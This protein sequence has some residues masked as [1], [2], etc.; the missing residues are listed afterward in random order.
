MTDR[1][2]C[3]RF[4]E[5]MKRAAVIIATLIACINGYAQHKCSIGLDLGNTLTHKSINI[6]A[7]YG[8]SHR[9]SAAWH[10]GM[11]TLTSRKEKDKEHDEHMAEFDTTQEKKTAGYWNSLSVQYWT[12]KF[13][14]GFYL[15]AGCRYGSDIRTDCIIGA[16]Y[17][18]PIWQGLRMTFSYKSDMLASFREGKP[19]GT[20]LTICIYWIIQKSKS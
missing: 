17:S 11:K 12:D 6:S 10:A 14:E 15:E 16:G 2:R 19:K 18:I 1:F 9:W 5:K 3:H 4:A 20:G 8:F 13:H 7:G